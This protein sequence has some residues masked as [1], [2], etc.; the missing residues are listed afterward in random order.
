MNAAATTPPDAA[1]QTNFANM[2]VALT[3]FTA[4]V[5]NPFFDPLG[6]VTEYLRTADASAGTAAVD[7]LIQQ[8]L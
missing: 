2:S 1:R 7:S 4:D 6:L 3:G 5:V 8:Y